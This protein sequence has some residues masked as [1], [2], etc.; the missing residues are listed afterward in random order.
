TMLFLKQLLV[1][2]EAQQGALFVA[3]LGHGTDAM[4]TLQPAWSLL[5]SV[6]MNEADAQETLA[7][8]EPGSD[9][10]QWSVNPPATLFWQ[11]LC[12]PKV[13]PNEVHAT[14]TRLHSVVLLLRWPATEQRMQTRTQQQA[15]QLLPLLTHLIDTILLH[16]LTA[17]YVEKP[18][19]DVFPAEL[20]ATVS[21]ELRSP[22]T[23]IQ[24]Y[25]ATLLRHDQ[26]ITREE[27]QDFLQAI[28]EAST[29]LSTIVERCL[30]LAQLETHMPPASNL[31]AVNMLILAQE[32]IT[33]V[34]ERRPSHLLL[35]PLL[36]ESA[37]GESSLYKKGAC[38]KVLSL[39]GKFRFGKPGP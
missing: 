38:H 6:D 29:H 9:Q 20:L 10:L 36:A 25:A 7:T 11:R 5:V 19:P 21:H 18:P 13:Y 15:I 33:A 34:K 23:M 28:G 26:H 27:R 30:T 16:L 8:F 22:L 37:A 14:M 3:P 32:S 35:V 12:T 4:D 39:S 17:Q 31:H 2:C 24:G 1:F